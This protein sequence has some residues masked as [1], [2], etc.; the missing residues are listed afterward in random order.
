LLSTPVAV[1]MVPLPSFSEPVQTALALLAIVPPWGI[2]ISD[3]V[4]FLAPGSLAA[5]GKRARLPGS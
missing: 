4:G 1:E 5:L 2:R 3:V